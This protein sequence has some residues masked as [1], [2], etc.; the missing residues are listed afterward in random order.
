MTSEN[1]SEDISEDIPENRDKR[2]KRRI[3]GRMQ[4][5]FAITSPEIETMCLEE[6]KACPMSV[7]DASVVEGGVIFKGRLWDMYAANLHLRT[8]NRI[9]MR[10]GEFKATNFRQFEKKL[11]DFPWELYLASDVIPKIS[12]N[13]QKSRLYHKDAIAELVLASIQSR[14]AN[15][16]YPTFSEHVFVRGVEDRFTLSIDTSGDL[17]YKRG[18]KIHVGKAPI[19]ETTAAAILKY[20]GYDPCEPLVD[21]LCGS[22][23]F[24]LEAAM[25]AAN[26][27]AGWFREFAFTGWQSFEEGRWK[28]LRREAEK[29]IIQPEQPMI[30]ASDIDQK[31]CDHLENSISE[32][33]LSKMISVSCADVFEQTSLGYTVSKPGLIVL[34]PPYGKRI[35]TFEDS[36]DFFIQLCQHIQ[37]NYKGWK[38]AIIASDKEVLKQISLKFKITPFFHG[39]MRLYLITGR[40]F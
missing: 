25:I 37:R 13:T 6:L 33:G 17:L 30:F 9:L 14:S 20:A 38:F 2:I 29:N 26:I 5:F 15:T 18:I 12:V 19:R 36:E 39:G 27:P 24:S 1:I 35:G 40:I 31:L 11:S 28:H 22:G 32:N 3:R 34:N 23:T 10:I 8:A 7:H 4:D 21:P 16:G